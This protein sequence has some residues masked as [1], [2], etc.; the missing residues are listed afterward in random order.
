MSN[1][2]GDNVIDYDIDNDLRG[3]WNESLEM[4]SLMSDDPAEDDLAERAIKSALSDKTA[5][6][7]L[8]A[9]KIAGGSKPVPSS[10]PSRTV[11]NSLGA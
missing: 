2:V 11:V 1:P 6:D 4:I 9:L 10:Q 7:A 8:A 5:L 3:L